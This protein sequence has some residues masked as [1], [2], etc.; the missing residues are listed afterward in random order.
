MHRVD[1]NLA[2]DQ[3]TREGMAK[4][5]KPDV[6]QT[7]TPNRR[8]SICVARPQFEVSIQPDRSLHL[9]FSLSDHLARH[10]M[11]DLFLDT[12]PYPRRILDAILREAGV[13]T[14]KIFSLLIE[15]WS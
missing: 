10:R 14:A 1:R 11:A 13:M 2:G 9:K 8:P 12:L 5:V 6:F 7:G 4:I 15:L 3:E